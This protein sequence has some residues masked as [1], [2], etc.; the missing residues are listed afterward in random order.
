MELKK[1]RLSYSI[2]G[3]FVDFLLSNQQRIKNMLQD[4]EIESKVDKLQDGREVKSLR[5]TKKT[6]SILFAPVRIDY[7]YTLPTV[8]T[9]VEETLE[10]AKAF[11]K[12]LAEIFPEVVGNRIAI[13]LSGF[14]ENQ[15]NKAIAAMTDYMKLSSSFGD[16]N[17][18]NFKINAPIQKFEMLNS[19][20]NVDMGTA[21]NNK[22]QQ[23][24]PVLLVSLDVNTL[25]ANKTPRFYA[26]NFEKDFDDIVEEIKVKVSEMEAFA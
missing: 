17:E 8:T 18:L 13:V 24:I 20:V 5:F 21:K 9:T 3:D 10:G 7:V 4:Y 25:A 6:I 15:D 12:L 26:Q 23:Q 19:V 2:I 1:I 14:I 22:T 11:Y 16:C